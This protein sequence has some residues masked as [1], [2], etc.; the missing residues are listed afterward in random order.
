MNVITFILVALLVGFSSGGY[1]GY[2]YRDGR[3]A[4]E[5]ETASLAAVD[6]ANKDAEAE[7]V[8]ALAAAK[9]E[10]AAR[11]ASR[12]SRMQGELDAAKKARAECAR[13]AE[14]TRLLLDSLRA[15]SGD[16]SAAPVVPPE[17]RGAAGA[18]GRD[19]L[20]NTPLGIRFGGL[21]RFVPSV[22]R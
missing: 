22:T 5:I 4:K 2:E 14:S 12:I 6:R 16:E 17:V 7:R 1:L 8:R 3:V 19:G 13:D 18:G 11:L 10:S 20:G 21:G 15:A 9:K